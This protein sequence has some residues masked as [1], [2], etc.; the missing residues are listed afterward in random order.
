[1]N[2]INCMNIVKW[3]EAQLKF[4]YDVS[5][6]EATPQQLHEALGKSVM[7]AIA[8]NWSLSKKTRQHARKAFY[9]SAEYLIGRL[10][11][12]NMFNLGILDRGAAEVHL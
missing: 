4:T 9:I 2:N 5:L 6:Q 12:S 10:V 1:M 3:T 7:M 11:Y 8:D